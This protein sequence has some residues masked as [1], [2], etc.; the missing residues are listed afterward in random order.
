MS[1]R[2][3]LKSMLAAYVLCS[4]ASQ[5]N[6]LDPS[7]G[8]N[9]GNVDWVPAAE[10]ATADA[11]GNIYVAGK[12]VDRGVDR[13]V[14]FVYSQTSS[15]IDRAYGVASQ[16]T[17]ASFAGFISDV[18]SVVV[19]SEDRVLV[20]GYVSLPLSRCPDGNP[21]SSYAFVTRF[22]VDGTLDT[23]FG[24]DGIFAGSSLMLIPC[25]NVTRTV[26]GIQSTGRIVVASSVE[27]YDPTS[28]YIFI[29]RLSADGVADGFFGSG[30]QTTLSTGT[31]EEDLT[32]VGLQITRNDE[33]VTGERRIPR[34]ST[35]GTADIFKLSADGELDSAFAKG[36][37]Y[38]WI[39]SEPAYLR[40]LAVDSQDE[41]YLAAVEVSASGDMSINR[42]KATGVLDNNFGVE[43]NATFSVGNLVSEP[44][45]LLFDS[46]GRLN[47]F[48]HSQDWEVGAEQIFLLHLNANG[49]L[50]GAV[51]SGG[52][53]AQPCGF[54]SCGFVGALIDKENRPIVAM[55]TVPDAVVYRYDELFGAGFD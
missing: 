47:I 30:G 16:A 48:G 7:F 49:S 4:A 42:L 15:G 45:E 18:T 1:I 41:I 54:A 13:G 27:P 52:L 31:A 5:A 55:D 50:N 32:L 11:K 19:D 46:H 37:I 39:P 3:G 9:P 40:A 38:H 28:P 53:Y 34:G 2:G 23:S 25:A 17:N 29:G 24:I 33:L 43:G 8:R 51:G 36:G 10:V 14:I 20:G 35:S 44:A 12:V 22:N 6:P 21:N 26:I